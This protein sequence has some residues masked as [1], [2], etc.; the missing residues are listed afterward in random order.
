MN[1]YWLPSIL[2]AY[3]QFGWPPPACQLASKSTCGP[4]G[5]SLMPHWTS[6]RC[7]SLSQD[8]LWE[9]CVPIILLFLFG[10]IV[11]WKSSLLSRL[12]KHGLSCAFV[13]SPCLCP[14]GRSLASY[15]LEEQSTRNLARGYGPY[16]P[17]WPEVVLVCVLKAFSMWRLWRR[18]D[19][20]A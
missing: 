16:Q 19:D 2:L 1:S 3:P 11:S 8:F 4:V 15:P 13:Q 12:W 14:L 10:T 20:M 17:R 9:C 6:T 18:P 7:P 5:T